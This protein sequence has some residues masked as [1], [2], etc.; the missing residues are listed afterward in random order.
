[1]ELDPVRC[2]AGPYTFG[3]LFVGAVLVLF[4]ATIITLG[5]G[6]EDREKAQHQMRDL[7]RRILLYGFFFWAGLLT[8]FDR[9]GCT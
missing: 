9:L 1:M 2:L 6:E 3:N 8:A 5:E 7:L 4:L